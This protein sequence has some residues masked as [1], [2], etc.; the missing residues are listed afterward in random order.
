MGNPASSYLLSVICAKADFLLFSVPKVDYNVTLK[1][2]SKEIRILVVRS[3]KESKGPSH[4][5][6]EREGE[7]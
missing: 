2:K 6:I 7:D 3:L 1:N 5:N 4:G